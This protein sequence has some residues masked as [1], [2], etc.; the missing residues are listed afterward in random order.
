MVTVKDVPNK[1]QLDEAVGKAIHALR[2]VIDYGFCMSTQQ[3]AKEMPSMRMAYGKR[4]ELTRL[5][6]EKE[7]MC[8]CAGCREHDAEEVAVINA[9]MALAYRDLRRGI[10]DVQFH[11][12]LAH[13]TIDEAINLLKMHDLLAVCPDQ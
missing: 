2:L 5:R 12:R 1:E 13:E 9:K 11:I 3:V 4:A 7:S 6:K 10:E 8:N